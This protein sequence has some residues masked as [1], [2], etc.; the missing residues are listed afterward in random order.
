MVKVIVP[1]KGFD[2]EIA[3]VQFKNGEGEFDNVDLAKA[4]AEDFGFEV[5]EEKVVKQPVK[6]STK[7]AGE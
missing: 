3:G 7:K 2:G 5:E 4:V 1:N 6:K